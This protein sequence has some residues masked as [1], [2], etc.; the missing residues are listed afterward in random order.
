ML[1]SNNATCSRPYWVPKIKFHRANRLKGGQLLSRVDEVPER[2]AKAS[3]LSVFWIFLRLGL[4]SF[5]GP[6]AHLGY[7]RTEFVERRKWI[8]DRDFSE[9]VAICQFLP[10]PTSS[11]VGFAIG[12]L[13]SG[14]GGATAAF[15]GFTLPSALLMLAFAYGASIFTGPIGEGLLI[16]LNIVA[17]AII[18][19]ALLGMIVSLTPDPTRAAIAFGALASTLIFAGTAGQILAIILGAIAGFLFS[20]PGATDIEVRSMRFPIPRLTG[21]L[22]LTAFLAILVLSPVI[23]SATGNSAL[24]L[25]DVSYRSG[26]LVFGGGHVVLPLL[27]TGVVD[28][29]WATNS[30]FLAGYGAAQALPGPLFAFAT[31]LG[32]VVSAGPGGVLG[33]LI[34][35]LGIFLPGFLLIV[36]VLPFWSM[37][38]HR[39]WAH[40]IARGT[41]AAVVGILASA[42][43]SPVFS[44][45][46]TGW[47]S[48]AVAGIGFLLLVILKIPPWI[49]VIFAA[50]GGIAI[51]LPLAN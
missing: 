34:A 35:T 20:K 12:I 8:S 49:V 24:M 5:G 3:S 26:A 2:G 46:I 41:G 13:R 47:L 27:Q 4:T 32:A 9:L 17:V 50:L 45:A 25:F 42:L 40:A 16:G 15:L 36:G 19:Q 6:I 44:S 43:Y 31:Y 29:G 18:A 22:S 37:I 14:F 7:F 39:T 23:A 33:A 10:G 51:T 1:C 11:Q 21:A 28:A 48:F 38:Q 30:Q